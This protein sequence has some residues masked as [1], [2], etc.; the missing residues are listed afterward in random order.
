ML[1]REFVESEHLLLVR[2]KI[3]RVENLKFGVYY[4]R[5][6]NN[7]F[8][9]CKDGILTILQPRALIQGHTIVN[10]IAFKF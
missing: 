2:H 3:F 7:C 8:S 1:A 10:E 5:R 6:V 4:T 9:L